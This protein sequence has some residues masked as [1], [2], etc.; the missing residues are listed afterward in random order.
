MKLIYK[1]TL[2]NQTQNSKTSSKEETNETEE[3]VS[4]WS[5]ISKA[6]WTFSPALKMSI[7]LMIFII[8]FFTRVFSVIRYESII[9]E[10]DPWFNYRATRV[11]DEKGYYKNHQQN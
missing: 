11:L 1:F 4:I 5:T 9:H 8:S 6:L 7:L 3:S 2:M 10:F